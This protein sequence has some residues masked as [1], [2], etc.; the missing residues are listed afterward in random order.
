M[1]YDAIN[2]EG[3][4]PTPRVSSSTTWSL[5]AHST[6]CCFSFSRAGFRLVTATARPVSEST[7][8]GREGA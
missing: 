2:S 5:R 1:S 3:K 8:Q 6:K 4:N 7:T